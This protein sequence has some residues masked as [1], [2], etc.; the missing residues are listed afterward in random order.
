[1]TWFRPTPRV[2]VNDP[3]LAREIV[4]NKFGH[5]QRRRNNGIVKRLANGL[6]SHEG[7]KWA[8]H[9]MII[10]PAFDVEKL[11]V[12][13]MLMQLPHQFHMILH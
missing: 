7:Q 5:F 9:L 1:M 12:I 4:G 11:K 8:A 3:K 2:I 6:V 10:S 13:S